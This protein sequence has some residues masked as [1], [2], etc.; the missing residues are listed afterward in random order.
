MP[1]RRQNKARIINRVTKNIASRTEAEKKAD[2]EARQSTLPNLNQLQASAKS[3]KKTQQALVQKPVA[4]NKETPVLKKA[5]MSPPLAKTGFTISSGKSGF[6]ATISSGSNNKANLY[7]DP[8]T[9]STI[10]TKQ[11]RTNIAQGK[12]YNIIASTASKTL[13]GKGVPTPTEKE[14][15]GLLGTSLTGMRFDAKAPSISA[16]DLIGQKPKTPVTPVSQTGITQ[17]RVD[18]MEEKQKDILSSLSNSTQTKTD[19]LP[20]VPKIPT[21]LTDLARKRRA[22]QLKSGGGFWDTML[23]SLLQ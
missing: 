10:A 22:K 23:R 13:L 9:G 7:K 2:Q 18:P 21:L 6:G 8:N 3:M 15:P 5:K 16:G 4:V 19:L 1:P 11:A 17:F 14:R 12:D 20:N